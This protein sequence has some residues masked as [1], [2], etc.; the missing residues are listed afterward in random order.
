VILEVGDIVPAIRTAAGWAGKLFR[1]EST[2]KSTS[3][4]QVELQLREHQPYIYDDANAGDKPVIPDTNITY[5]KP[6]TPS[7]GVATDVYSNFV[8]VLLT[9]D[10]GTLDH[11]LAIIDS[12][13]ETLV[14]TRINRRSYQISNLPVGTYTAYVKAVGGLARQSDGYSFAFTITQPP[15]P[16]DAPD[17]QINPGSIVLTPEQPARINDIY[18]GLWTTNSG[19]DPNSDSVAL[20]SI[21]AAGRSLAIPST[22]NQ[23]YYLWYRL[24][25]VEGDG[26]WLVRVIAGEAQAGTP[27]DRG[28]GSFYAT[29]STWSDSAA[30]TAT[31]GSNVIGDRV[32]IS[33]SSFSATRYWNGASWITVDV[34]IDANWIFNN[35]VIIDNLGAGA[36]T[37]DKINLGAGF[38]LDG[39]GGLSLIP[40]KFFVSNANGATIETKYPVIIESANNLAPLYINAV[41]LGNTASSPGAQI[42]ND[43][44]SEAEATLIL[45][46]STSDGYALSVQGGISLNHANAVSTSHEIYQDAQAINATISG[47]SIVVTMSVGGFFHTNQTT[48]KISRLGNDGVFDQNSRVYSPNNKPAWADVIG[49]PTIP[50]TAAEVGAL[51]TST[52]A[53][54]IGALA[55]SGTATN[56]NALQWNGAARSPSAS[57]SANAIVARNSSGDISVATL[58]YTSLVD[59]SSEDIKED[60]KAIRKPLEMVLK[61]GRTA[62]KRFKYKAGHGRYQGRRMGFIAQSLAPMC[63]DAVETDMEG[64]PAVKSVDM[65]APLY[66]AMVEMHELV[67]AQ[68][69]IIADLQKRIKALEK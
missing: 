69:T 59:S 67:E 52:T 57:N 38:D 46:N 58:F 28:A 25:T 63:P 8:Q 19:L 55:T 53:A 12:S 7:N 6:A 24:K 32:T 45:N 68:Q 26:I 5:A 33:N 22:L 31:T 48:S 29:G 47:E 51:P 23:T 40:N 14:S 54:D 39:S 42:Y 30:N 13:D 37:A 9:W 15:T 20:F 41:P 16:T 1:I 62:T 18:E 56:S 2:E 44:T 61:I 17:I 34:V 43:S 36:I 49:K 3:N 66:P 21:I 35:Q 65:V 50:T 27:G 64:N 11:G 60:I 4:G 10:S